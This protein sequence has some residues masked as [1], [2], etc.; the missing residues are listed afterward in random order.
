MFIEDY[1]FS[2][3]FKEK[4][5]RDELNFFED[6]EFLDMFVYLTEIDNE[7]TRLTEEINRLSNKKE[8]LT[9]RGIII[10]NHF[11]PELFRERKKKEEEV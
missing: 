5:N 9:Q 3:M 1:K 6:I 4:F 10:S 7:I 2:N 11:S 8:E